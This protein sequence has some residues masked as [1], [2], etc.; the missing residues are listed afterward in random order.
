MNIKCPNPNCGVILNAE[1]DVAGRLVSCA[2]C[3]HAFHV[4]PALPLVHDPASP[5]PQEAAGQPPIV[6]PVPS[7]GEG[8]QKAALAAVVQGVLAVGLCAVL[9]I[10][11][12]LLPGMDLMIGRASLSFWVR[13][14]LTVGIVVFMLRLLSP[15]RGL[16]T[17][18][19]GLMFR[20]SSALSSDIEAQK[21]ISSAGL[22][23]VLLLYAAILYQA[24]IPSILGAISLLIG[25]HPALVALI[26][27]AFAATGIVLVIKI[28]LTMKPLATR[29]TSKVTERAAGLAANVDPQSCA[30]CGSHLAPEMK[31]CPSCGK[32]V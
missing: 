26:K 11:V 6:M 16:T 2:S 20:A 13:A 4:P 10:V 14:A 9:Q 22:Y 23:T 18:Y 5:K 25:Y 27:L 28:V 31:V 19:I 7:A 1:A 32:P 15:L 21:A 17:Y 24:A 3:G 8:T 12:D 29:L 30:S